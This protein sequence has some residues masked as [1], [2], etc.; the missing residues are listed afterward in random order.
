MSAS[1]GNFTV[2]TMVR[3]DLYKAYEWSIEEGW[4][5]G[6]YD[7]DV[8]FATDPTGFFI[9]ELNGEPIGSVSGVAYDPHFGFVGIYI[10]RPQYRGLGYGIQIFNAAMQYLGDRTVGLDGVI[11]QQDNYRRSGFEFCYRNIRNEYI[12]PS[13]TADFTGIVSASDVP[14]EQLLAYDTAHFPANRPVFLK[15]L[16][17]E[18]ESTALVSLKDGEIDGFGVIRAF[19]HGWSVGPLFAETEA[20]ANKLFA[21][22]SSGH[23]GEP[24]YLDTPEPNNGAKA[25][26][27]R[28]GMSP[29]FETARM[30][31]GAIPQIPIQSMY[32][33][34][35]YEL[36]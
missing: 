14:F 17:A 20:T 35:T 19:S 12:P 31:R 8:F 18:P 21:A 11:A 34:T 23:V 6:K 30:Y 7:H 13:G 29:V 27:A 2:R 16:I 36:G 3:E 26:V 4:N 25:L 9:G 10:L 32:G 28:F 5:I 33:V 15:G 22:L 24:V 1:E